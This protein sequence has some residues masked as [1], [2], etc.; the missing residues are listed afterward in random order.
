MKTLRFLAVGA[1]ILTTPFAL[2]GC[3]SE[4]KDARAVAVTLGDF[5]I[6]T[7]TNS[8][9]AGAVTFKI[10]NA[11]G[12]EHEMVVFKVDAISDIPTKA[13]G[14]ADEEGVNESL[15]MGEIAHIKASQSK[16]WKVT[17]PAGKYVLLCNLNEGGHVHYQ[18]GMHTTFTVT[19]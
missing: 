3:S 14:E 11:G 7:K 19:A 15:H 5:V 9:P 17:L 12:L 8:V 13:D 16:T 10:K 6:R 2:A 4:K 1:L 18:K